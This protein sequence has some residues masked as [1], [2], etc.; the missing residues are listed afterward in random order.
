MDEKVVIGAGTSYPLDGILALPEDL[1]VKVP[2]VLLVQG[3]GPTDK[4]ETVEA[5]KPFLDIAEYLKTR[6]IASIRYNKR[7][8]TYG[9]QMTK[10][11]LGDIT[12]EGETIEDAL[13]AHE[14]LRADARIDPDNIYLLGHSLGGMLAPRID[15]ESS[16]FAG[17]I[18]MAGSP[19]TLAEIMLEQ[20]EDALAQLG[21][22]LHK[23][24]EMQVKALRTQFEMIPDMTEEKARRTKT[25]GKS[26]AWYFKEM[27]DHPTMEYLDALTKPVLILQGDKDFQVSPERD[28]QLYQQLCAGKDNIQ[29]KLYPGLNH[30][31]MK[32]IYKSVKDFKKEYKVLQHVD[33]QVLTDIADWVLGQRQIA[34]APV[35]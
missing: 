22:I 1:S 13:M 11:G 6:G 30:L 21:M 31:F 26:Y 23:V 17:I 18:I 35:P 4:D 15:A 8:F 33:E 3:S 5:N 28:F 29:F 12:V 2:A 24:G 27:S 25:V 32:S 16:G 9:E 34:I 10:A 14:I 19:R 7:T 20:S